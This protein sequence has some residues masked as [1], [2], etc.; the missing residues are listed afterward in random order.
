M[1]AGEEGV[2]GDL[3]DLDVGGVGCGAGEAEAGAGEDGLVL[4]I[5]LVAMAVA[6]ADFGLAVGVGGEG[7]GLHDAVP[8]SEAH[9]AAHLFDAGELAEFVD[10]A[11]GG[12][13]VKLTGV[14]AL[15]AADVGGV[16][17]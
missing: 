6:F 14:G 1:G 11:V 10:D 16:L 3:Y 8:G 2:G 4:A 12:G 15:E 13:G 9:G 7:V 5:E 17:D